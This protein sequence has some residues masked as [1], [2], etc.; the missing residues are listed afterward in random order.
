MIIIVECNRVWAVVGCPLYSQEHGQGSQQVIG[1]ATDSLQHFGKDHCA[2]IS[3]LHAGA[4]HQGSI[5]KRQTEAEVQHVAGL[6]R[7]VPGLLRV[8]EPR[9]HTSL[10]VVLIA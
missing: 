5:T 1:Q 4:S 10:T 6:L 9:Q 2:Y 3:G 7:V 8:V